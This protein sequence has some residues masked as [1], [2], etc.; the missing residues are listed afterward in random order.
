MKKNV[1][2]QKIGGQLVSATDGS[3]VTSGTVTVYVTGDAGTQAAGSVGAGACTH[4]GNGYWT[5]APAQAETNYDL[6]AFT[7]V[8]AGAVPSTVQ[9]FTLAATGVADIQARIPAA[10]SADGYMKVASNIKINTALAGFEFLM[11]DSTNHNP[12]TGKTVTVTRSIDGAAF[13]AAANAVAEVSAGIY[14]LDL[15][16]ADLNGKSV[17][18]RATGAG[19]DDTFFTIVTTA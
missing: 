11:T 3:A 10:L 4:E 15:S 17:T 13:A 14:K 18:F 12:A 19:C 1:A 9:V 16:A 7:F 8:C 5:Y 6:I 2:G